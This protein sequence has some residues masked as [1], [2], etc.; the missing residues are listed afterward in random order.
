ML[1]ETHSDNQKNEKC[2][3]AAKEQEEEVVRM[4]IT[5]IET[6]KGTEKTST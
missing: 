6:I 3:I 5:K 1:H 4:I 2:I